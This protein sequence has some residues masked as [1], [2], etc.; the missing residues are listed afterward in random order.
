MTTQDQVGILTQTNKP[1]SKTNG[2]RGGEG[3]RE[4]GREGNGDTNGKTTTQIVMC[5]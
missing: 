4:R 2:G 3:G 5:G 1:A